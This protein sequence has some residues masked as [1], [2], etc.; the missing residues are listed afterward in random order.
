MYH[1][2]HNEALHK[3]DPVLIYHEEFAR[4][5]AIGYMF[6]LKDISHLV[7]NDLSSVYLRIDVGMRMAINPGVNVAVGY[8]F[9]QLCGKC[10]VQD[11]TFVMW[12]NYLQRRKMVRHYHNM[13]SGAFCQT[14]FDEIQAEGMHLVELLCLKQLPLI[15]Y[16]PKVIHAF[17]NEILISRGNLKPKR[18]HDKVCIIN[19]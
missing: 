6:I 12:C 17:P 19:P 16:L 10:T 15:H 4:L 11:R 8:E 3:Y 2:W 18:T 1:L 14:A 13:L 5:K 7:T 9:T